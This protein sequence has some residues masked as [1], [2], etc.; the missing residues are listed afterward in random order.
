MTDCLAF[1][2]RLHNLNSVSSSSASVSP[3][4]TGPS[5]RILSGWS[6]LGLLFVLPPLCVADDP[7]KES[8]DSAGVVQEAARQFEYFQCLAEKF[9]ARVA[10]GS[11]LQLTRSPFLKWTIGSSWHGSFYVWTCEGKPVLVGGFLADSGTPDNRRAFVEMHSIADEPLT[12]LEIAGTKKHVWDPDVERT[13]PVVLDDV[14]EPAATARLRGVQMRD[15]ARTFEVTMQE[16]VGQQ[17]LRLQTTPLFRYADSADATRD[18]AFFAFVND[19]GTDPE[20][21]LAIECDLKSP[22]RVWQVR[23]MRFSTQALELRRDGKVVWSVA[24]YNET[25]ES[26]K[27]T[28]P[29]MIVM[30][31]ETTTKSFNSIRDQAINDRKNPNK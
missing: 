14:S 25:N 27:L 31:V 26:S 30:L 7:Q 17:E 22:T 9:E 1:S 20:L 2:R 8:S 18:G 29:Y 6:I 21:L 15:L 24:K 16:Q 11:A 3:I 10:S 5:M 19:K 23:P 28:D 13:K 4:L 12:P